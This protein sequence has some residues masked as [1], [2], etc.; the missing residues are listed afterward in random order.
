MLFF[1]N[2]NLPCPDFPASVSGSLARQLGVQASSRHLVS[3]HGVVAVEEAERSEL[4][5]SVGLKRLEVCSLVWLLV[6]QWPVSIRLSLN[7]RRHPFLVIGTR[8]RRDL[9]NH[10][11]WRHLQRVLLQA[12][13]ASLLFSRT[14]RLISKA[15]NGNNMEL[16]GSSDVAFHAHQTCSMPEKGNERH[17][18][19]FAFLTP[20]R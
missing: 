6:L 15:V 9:L 2:R 18:I 5:L 19:A 14:L 10:S 17:A 1:I 20:S 7:S 3:R 4:L 11:A 13:Y 12:M 8:P 16:Y